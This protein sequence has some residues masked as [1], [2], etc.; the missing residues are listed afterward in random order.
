MLNLRAKDEEAKE[1]LKFKMPVSSRWSDPN[2]GALIFDDKTKQVELI[3]KVDGLKAAYSP[4]IK[5]NLQ[6]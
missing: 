4:K 3:R 1:V 5:N 2:F 6:R